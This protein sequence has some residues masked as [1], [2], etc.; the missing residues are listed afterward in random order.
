MAEK[1]EKKIVSAGDATAKTAKAAAKKVDE[2]TGKEL[3]ESAPVGN[4]KGLRWGAVCLWILALGLEVVALLI[5]VGRI[6]ITF[7]NNL[8]PTV[9]QCVIA[10]VLDF[11]AVVA[12]AQL[13]KKANH[14]DP[15]SEKNKLKFWLWNNMG[16][17]AA[18]FCFVPFIILVLANKDL[19]KQSKT[20][21]TAAAAVL[22][23]AGG[24]LSADWNPVSTEM[25]D[26]AV[27]EFGDQLVYWAPFGKVYHTH[28]DC[29]ALNHTDTLTYGS[30]DQAIAANRTRLCSF[31]AKRDDIT[32]LATDEKDVSAEDILVEDVGEIDL[33]EAAD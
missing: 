32:N 19:D 26:A 24:L 7:L 12:G 20:I 21:A 29:Q 10:L 30:V 8:I 33:N 23:V 15:V 22:L 2:A 14:I 5:L 17:I 1:K 18:A 3:K 28:Q 27:N 13:W 31:C 4:P 6:N 9:W 25:K 11:A 16:V